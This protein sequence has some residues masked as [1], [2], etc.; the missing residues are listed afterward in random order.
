M[1]GSFLRQ[2]AF[3]SFNFFPLDHVSILRHKLIIEGV[4]GR[5]NKGA[6]LLD[7][8]GLEASGKVIMVFGFKVG[9]HR[10]GTA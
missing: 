3:Q 4:P 1:L 8:V 7:A 5:G 2:L 9:L 10:K 6:P